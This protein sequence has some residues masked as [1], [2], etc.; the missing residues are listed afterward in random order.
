MDKKKI[1]N[2]CLIL[3]AGVVYLA[4]SAISGTIFA[5][6]GWPIN[7]DFGLTYPELLALVLAGLA[8]LLTYKSQNFMLYLEESVSELMKVTYP[9]PKKS[10]QSAA[11]VVVVIGAAM[12]VIWAFDAMWTKMMAVIL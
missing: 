10:A 2:I 11:W 9:T 7:R 12:V 8:L 1:L 6:A 4:L 3:A 5:Q